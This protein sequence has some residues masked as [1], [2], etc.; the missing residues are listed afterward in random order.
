MKIAS[1]TLALDASHAARR[2]HTVTERLRV[3]GADHATA[4]ASAPGRD[5]RPT[6]SLSAA[7]RTLADTPAPTAATGASA[8]A[9][10]VDPRM[11]LLRLMIEYWTGQPVRV[12]S[13]ADLD[14]TTAAGDPGTVAAAAAGTSAGAPAAGPGI[15]YDRSEVRTESETTR[16]AATG[17]VRTQ[18][19]REIRFRVD[20]A[21]AREFR[22]ESNVALRLGEPVRKQDPLVLNLDADAVALESVRMDFDLDADGSA[23]S[24]ARLA[25][26]SAYLVFDG[27][28]NGRADDGSELFGPATGNGF[29]ELAALDTDANGWID[30]GDAG[31]KTLALWAPATGDGLRPLAAAGVG[32]LATGSVGTPFALRGAGN[33]ALGEVR[34]TGVWLADAG[35]AGTVQQVDLVV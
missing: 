2:E 32:A 33:A 29:A 23:E 34:A 9:E 26:G 22:E 21:M 12:L 1:S 8:S 19:G 28:G 3:R 4:A 31:W 27:N 17:V 20:V 14:V 15:A 25:R 7:G 10:T 5:A 6:V 30:E 13:A 24:I 16:F 18:D 11:Q 35:G